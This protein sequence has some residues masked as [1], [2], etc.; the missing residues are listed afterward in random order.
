MHLAYRAEDM[1]EVFARVLALGGIALAALA[2]MPAHA[3]AGDLPDG[4]Y[5]RTVLEGLTFPTAVRFAP[6]GRIFVAEKDGVLKVFDGPEDPVPEIYA[7]L[8]QEVN[9]F[10]DRGLLGIALDPEFDANGFVYALYTY[11]AAVGETAPDQG[12]FPGPG[13]DDTCVDHCEVTGRLV[14]LDRADGSLHGKVLIKDAW[15]NQWQ[16]HSIGA[17]EF[18]AQGR[19][20]VSGGDGANFNEVD[21]GQQIGPVEHRPPPNPCGD[22]PGPENQALS[23][24]DAEGGALRSQDLRTMGD[25]VDLSGTI[26]R[27]DPETGDGIPANPL[28]SSPDPNARR[29]LA[30]G[31]R[32]PFR[33]VVAPGGE[34]WTADTGWRDWE[35]INTF[36]SSASTPVNFGW[37]C[38]EG[39]AP[40]PGY[41]AAALDICNGLYLSPA[42]ASPPHFN[43]SHHAALY[44]TDPCPV[45]GDGS[46]VTAVELYGGDAFPESYEG[47]LFFGDYARHCIWVMPEGPPDGRPS[48]SL[49]TAFDANVIAPVDLEVGPDGALYYVDIGLG[50]VRRID[51]TA[52]NHPPEAVASA[53]PTSG[54]TPLEVQFDGSGSTDADAGDATTLAWDLDGDGAYDD[55]TAVNPVHTYDNAGTVIAGLRVEDSAGQTDV[56]TVRIDAGNRPPVANIAGP[57]L[58]T[59]WAAGQPLRLQGTAEDPEDGP[60]QDEGALRWTIDLNHC[61]TGGGCHAH[62]LQ[63]VSG[64]DEFQLLAPDHYYPA[65]LE[66]G[67]TA[68][69]SDGLESEPVQRRLNPRTVELHLDSQPPGLALDA[70]GFSASTPFDLTAIEDSAATVTAPTPQV[71]SG[72]QYSWL[73]WSDGGARTHPLKLSEP[74]SLTAY[75]GPRSGGEEPPPADP[76]AGD[77][78]SLEVLKVRE[79]KRSAGLAERGVR[80]LVRCGIECELSVKLLGVGRRA[81]RLGLKGKLGGCASELDAQVGQWLRV[82]PGRTARRKLRHRP[83]IGAGWVVPRFDVE[84][85]DPYREAKRRCR[86]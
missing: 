81:R 29:V 86:P 70:N 62:H 46:A 57:G 79:P 31:L 18:D 27:V 55:S 53:T 78:P 34:V 67:L 52:D 24:P 80:A 30:Y 12:T 61:V 60:L 5:E 42:D 36:S 84:P 43:Y 45:P 47:A 10:G 23:A 13:Y 21:Y 16:S 69:D 59:T 71:S 20:Y 2:A 83:R 11:D 66:I 32:N 26:A 74:R 76:P 1:S 56:D 82:R 19:L 50:E 48:P 64:S 38:Y 14:R 68:T 44:P 58:G 28:S 39:Y 35:E 85:R 7:D 3:S 37:P 4:F 6:D 75:F 17:V 54:P 72:Q 51:Y 63:T 65:H 22:P 73:E 8:R 77:P 41:A 15:C 40:Q 49:V 33:F 25:P 9:N